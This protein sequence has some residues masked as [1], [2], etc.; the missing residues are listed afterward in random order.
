[1]KILAL[2][3]GGT[4][5]KSAL[6]INEKMISN[7]TIPS[8][9]K[10]GGPHIV[11][12]I[13]RAIDFY[14]D[15]D[16][17]GISTTGQVNNL[18]GSIHYAND[19]VPNFTG[20]QLGKIIKNKYKKQVFVEN[21][22]NAAAIGE[23][24]FGSGK[25]EKNFLCLTYGTGVGGAIILDNEI[26]RGIDGV[27]GEMG[28]IIT[29]VNGRKCTCGQHGCYE[30]YASTTALVRQIMKQNNT[31]SNGKLIF[32]YLNNPTITMEDKNSIISIIDN[33]IDEISYGLVSLIHVLNPSCIVLGGGI[34]TQDIIV[35]KIRKVTYSRLM[36]SFKNIKIVPTKLGNNAG[37]YGMVSIAKRQVNF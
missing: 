11:Q 25:D 27:A 13:M 4:D 23:G 12:N 32:S 35:E 24:T 19:N 9:G 34:M 8:E 37:L 2:D 7:K 18:D 1:M 36:D 21:D 30:Q 3:V 20:C 6:I 15:Y 10:K 17:I 14:S 33:W 29:H 26:Y 28:H 16:I 5:I 31:L 22:V